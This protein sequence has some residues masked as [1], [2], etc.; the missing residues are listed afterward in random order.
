MKKPVP[1]AKLFVESL[2]PF[3]Q[4]STQETALVLLHCTDEFDRRREMVV[5]FR[6][7]P[8]YIPISARIKHKL[9]S[10][11]LLQHVHIYL[12]NSSNCAKVVELTQKLLRKYTF[13]VVRREVWAAKHNLLH[14]YIEHGLTVTQMLIVF[15]KIQQKNKYSLIPYTDG[16]LSKVAFYN[17]I[18]SDITHISKYLDFNLNEITTQLQYR[19]NLTQESNTSSNPHSIKHI[20]S[21]ITNENNPTPTDPQELTQEFDY[22]ADNDNE[23]N[24]SHTTSNSPTPD[25]AQL[26]PLPPSPPIIPAE[27]PSIPKH[28]NI[29]TTN[30]NINVNNNRT[31]ENS[32]NTNSTNFTTITQKC[33]TSTIFFY[34]PMIFRFP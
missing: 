19:K 10:S 12:E 2:P 6:Q 24:S 9:T 14:K 23:T 34:I 7:D 11:E 17:Y 15:E 13:N 18:F 31:S 28:S 22:N 33:T 5:F 21:T 29:N 16:Y 4:S 27:P 25:E 30:I 26:P 1:I 8:S 32:S 3:L 20:P